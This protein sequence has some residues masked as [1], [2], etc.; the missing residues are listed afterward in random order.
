I[1]FQ[2]AGERLNAVLFVAAGSGPHPTVILFHGIPGNERNLDLAQVLRR[3]GANV[4]YFNYRGTWAS[5]GLF[6]YSHALEDVAAALRYVG[7]SEIASRYH[8]APRRVARVG[9]SFGGW[10]ALRG[11]A[12]DENIACVAG[13][14]VANMGARGR[15]FGDPDR[16]SRATA[17]NETLIA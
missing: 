7:S 13:I 10:V 17:N 4:L 14:D 1:S 2:S 8:S 6:S 9:H 5:G 3:A 12:A 11:A 16:A 15:R